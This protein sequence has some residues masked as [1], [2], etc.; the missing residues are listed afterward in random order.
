[1]PDI[2]IGGDFTD[3]TTPE[4]TFSTASSTAIFKIDSV[5]VTGYVVKAKV[6]RTNG[7]ACSTAEIFVPIGTITTLA[8]NQRVE[9][10]SK[11]D[12]GSAYKEFDGFIDAFEP[13]GAL[14][15][16]FSYDAMHVAV[17]MN[18]TNKTFD[19]TVDTEA[20]VVSEI[21]KNLLTQAGLT[22]NSGATTIQSTSS[23]G[24]PTLSK[25]VCNE[26]DIFE[27]LIRLAKIANWQF[28][29]KAHDNNVY[30]E[31]KGYQ[32]S[33]T[34]L[35]VGTNVV[36]VPKWRKDQTELVNTL[37]VK[38]GVA[39]VQTR[40]TFSGTGVQTAF[41]LAH[42]PSSIQVQ[43][44]VGTILTG[45][46]PNST[47]SYDYYLNDYVTQDGTHI[48]QVVFVSAPAFGASNIQVNYSYLEAIP[49]QVRAG[50][51]S[52]D[53]YGVKQ[54]TI[55]LPD[56][57][58]VADA[59]V[60]AS[61]MVTAYSNP[62]QIV[63]LNYKNGTAAYYVGQT[64]SVSDAVNATSNGFTTA[65][66]VMNMQVVGYPS[67]INQITAGNKDWILA[68]LNTDTQQR[69]ARLEATVSGQ[70]GSNYIVQNVGA[71]FRMVRTQLDVRVISPNDWFIYDEGIQYDANYIYDCTATVD[72]TTT[73]NY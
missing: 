43:Y 64:I 52:S 31:P 20:G 65:T 58:T 5:D 36:S 28:Y 24:V 45:G 10:W 1:M 51:S 12:D 2:E 49:V 29:Y 16:I 3:V 19:A 72:S 35:V 26:N 70:A 40:E 54:K 67:P 7:Y 46:V 68:D 27:L 23:F 50:F 4:V 73:Y 39:D 63:D 34:A 14:I 62:F 47:A 11:L 56:T 60:F 69:V 61:N 25:F 37:T 21:F 55:T 42:V 33:G 8:P 57:L 71:N 32:T 15:R 44:P 18:A 66:L 53:A 48:P 17:D 13:Q 9:Y 22:Y 38:G 30:F 41:N 59:S 6:I